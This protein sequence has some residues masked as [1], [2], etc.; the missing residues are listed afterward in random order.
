MLCLPDRRG[1]RS[2]VPTVTCSSP[3]T[4]RASTSNTPVRPLMSSI[5]PVPTGAVC[6]HS[7]PSLPQKPPGLAIDNSGGAT[8]GDV[9]L[10]SGNTELSSLY[11]YGPTGPADT[12]EVLRTGA[13]EGTVISEPAGIACGPACLAEYDVGS[14]ITLAATPAPGSA[15][16]GWSGGACS[17]PVASHVALDSDTAVSAEF[18]ALSPQPLA[19][20]APAALNAAALAPP[21]AA[22]RPP[23]VPV[24]QARGQRRHRRRPRPKRRQPP[25]Q[26]RAR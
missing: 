10:T 11:A 26:R 20:P 24:F 21:T 23:A 19:A 6:R 9:Y 2:T 22:A 5:P 8:Q 16:V 25:A 7:Q 17:G 3:T 14:E 12:L 4:C 13:G 18:E 15:F 1:A